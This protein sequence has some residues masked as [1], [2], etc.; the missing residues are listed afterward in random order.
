MEKGKESGMGKVLWQPSEDRIEQANMTQFIT[1]VNER[2]GLH[3]TAYPSLYTW[4][5]EHI[6]AFWATMWAFGGIKASRGYWTVVDDVTKFPGAR[7][8]L[9]ARLNFA[10]NLLQ[11]RDDHVAFIGRGETQQ[12]TTMTYAEVWTAVGRLAA[13]LR[14]IGVAPGDRVCAYLPNVVEAVLAMLAATSIGATWASCGMELGP[15]AVRDRL[16]QIEPTV[17]FTADGYVYKGRRF[18]ALPNVAQIVQGLPSLKRVVVVS[19]LDPDPAIHQLP[20]AVPFKELVASQPPTDPRFEQL[21]FDHPVYIMFSSGTTGKP[22]CLVQGAGGVLINHLKELLLHTDVKRSD[23]ITYL[24]SCSWM[25]WNWLLSALAVGATLVLYDGNPMY[26]DPGAMWHLV[27]EDAITIFGCSASYLNALRRQQAH[28]GADY[29]LASLREISQ[30]GSPLSTDGFEFVYTHIKPDVH[31]NSISGGTDLNGCFAMGSPTLPVHA[32][33]IQAAALGMK[34]K[35]YDE[36]GNP[37]LDQRGELVCEAPS[38]SMPL[39][40]WSDPHRDQY[41]AAYFRFYPH[42][43]VWRHGDYVMLHRETGGLTFFG[44]SDT[45]IK[46]SGVRVGTAE[47]YNVLE[48][49]SE[50]ADCLAVGQQWRDEERLILYVKLAPGQQLT[51]ALKT[52]I[53]ATLRQKAS[54]RHVPAVILDVPDIPYTFNMKKVEIAVKNILNNQPI[55]NQEAILNPES[56]EYFKRRL[57]KP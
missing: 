22:K 44:R 28:P 21:P 43:A 9:G 11:Y 4:S 47:I 48:T 33:E 46:P 7:W 17:L 42:K 3:L 41:H 13:A 12:P 49:I 39:Y 19:H 53:R 27:Q 56:L 14:A 20:H 38:P 34:I 29:D 55:Q 16:G 30:T 54:P 5:I 25:M 35:V 51:E 6:P 31:L 26:P 23:V 1:F 57:P 15:H 45:V 50:V 18:K 37:I 36:A 8:F 32:G 52:Q 40:F 10:E 24:T 2:H